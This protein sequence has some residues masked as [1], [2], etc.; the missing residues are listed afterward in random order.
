MFSDGPAFKRKKNSNQSH[1]KK[2][3]EKRNYKD[4]K[5]GFGGKKKGSKMNNK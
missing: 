4:K 5:F 2:H 3:I 1:N